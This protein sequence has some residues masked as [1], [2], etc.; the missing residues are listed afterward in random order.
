MIA[1]LPG[2]AISVVMSVHNGVKY[3]LQA[4][5]SILNQTL[6][7]FEFIIVDDG[8]TDGASQILETYAKTDS[9]IV[10]VGQANQGLTKSL[11]KALYLARGDFIARM[12]SDDVAHPHRL[13]TQ[14]AF[15]NSH[16]DI[17]CVGSEVELISE[18]GIRLGPR[19]QPREHDEIRRL[20]LL[21]DGGAMTHPAIMFRRE[22]AIKIAGYDEQFLTAQ[23][24]DFFLRISE[25]GRV[26]NIDEILLDWRQHPQSINRTKSD[27]WR[28][29][30]IVAIEKTIERIGAHNYS[31]QLFCDHQSFYFPSTGFELAGRAFRNNR[32]KE[33]F[34]ILFNE[35]CIG[36]N[37][38]RALMKV[39]KYSTFMLPIFLKKL[40]S[41]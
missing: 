10:L 2:P 9:R 41:W 15:L 28:S 18:N 6:Y 37:R 30:K 26:A 19:N 27:T 3:L 20:L 4:I 23:D 32:R 11:N 29:M 17:V 24:L 38:A 16:P 35:I 21:G 31:S 36:R 8:S 1:R 14:L 5:E 12:D 7:D 25:V 39:L 33:A 13:E 40:M 22:Q 34:Q